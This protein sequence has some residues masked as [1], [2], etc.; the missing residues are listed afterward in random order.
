LFGWTEESQGWSVKFTDN[1]H[2]QQLL[3]ITGTIEQLA[4]IQLKNLSSLNNL[5]M[6]IIKA[7]SLAY[8][9]LVLLE[10]SP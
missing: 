10:E 9:Y 8:Q 4:N 3:L 1:Q 7:V 5:Q 2:E 6:S